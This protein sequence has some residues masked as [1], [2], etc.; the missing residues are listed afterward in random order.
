MTATGVLSGVWLV[1]HGIGGVQDLPVPRWLFY[2]A[3]AIVLVVSFVLLGA[4]WQRP[5]LARRSAGRLLRRPS[6][7]SIGLARRVVQLVSLLLFVL[8]WLAALFGDT[9]PFSNLAPTWIY[10]AFWLGVPLLSVLFG[11]VWRA[12]SPWRAIADVSVWV[13]ERTGRRATPLA[14]YPERLGRWPAAVTLGAFAALELAY[15]D[16]SSPRALAFAI[17]LYTYVALFGMMSFGRE[18]WC[19]RGEGFA[20]AFSYF[21]LIAPFEIEAGRLRL[22]W[23][24][25]G[26]AR[27]EPLPGSIAVVAVMLGSVM[28]DGFSR[29]SWWQDLLAKIEGPYL[30]SRPGVAELLVTATNVAGLLIAAALVGLAFRAACSAAGLLV[31]SPRDLGPEFVLS[32]VPIAFAYLVAHYFSLFVVQGQ[33]LIP[34]VSDP[35]GQGRDLLGTVDYSPDLVPFSPNTVWYVQAGALVVGHVV[36]LAIAHD[37][38]VTIFVERRAALRSQLPMLALMVL[39]TVGGLWILSRP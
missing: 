31:D 27:S 26:L 14:E 12:L 6:P 33:F 11:D 30:I 8:V 9:D 3:G 10:I 4:L 24:F 19:T 5:V 29:S 23:P 34:L 38:A 28:F 20:V 25:A 32:L 17:A 35:F 37:R 15:S 1:A 22:R 7:G 2:W 18:C 21:A 39:Y 13:I 16:P 36:A